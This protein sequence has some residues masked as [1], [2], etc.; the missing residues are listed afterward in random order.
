MI[1]LDTLPPE[2][3][4]HLW[5]YIVK[6]GDNRAVALACRALA[7][8]DFDFLW[9]NRDRIF[10]L[11]ER[12]DSFIYRA[13]R[14]MTKLT[15]RRG[16]YRLNQ[17]M[18]Y[19]IRHHGGILP[20]NKPLLIEDIQVCSETVERAKEDEAL[21]KLWTLIV[22]HIHHF[23]PDLDPIQRLENAEEMRNWL[24]A[25]P[26]L[27]QPIETLHLS[28]LNLTFIPKEIGLFANLKHLSLE[29]N[30]LTN[31]C[32]AIQSLEHLSYLNLTNNPS[33]EFPSTIGKL[34]HH[35]NG[36]YFNRQAL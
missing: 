7:N 30:K 5:P 25:H 27:L 16:I 10:T 20:N 3:L 23:N 19:L 31:I 8:A 4:L 33:L 21:D 9:S 28:S 13:I 17:V 35:G 22:P 1:T 11:A 24:N 26:E 32:P 29:K 36:R 34:E 14:N 15:S 18:S 2:V 12:N 6:N